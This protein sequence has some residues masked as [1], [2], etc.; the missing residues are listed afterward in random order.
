MT[1]LAT[2]RRLSER[3]CFTAVTSASL[4]FSYILKTKLVL[5]L[6][7]PISY[8]CCSVAMKGDDTGVGRRVWGERLRNFPPLASS[9]RETNFS[10]FRTEILLNFRCPGQ[11]A[12]FIQ[13]AALVFRYC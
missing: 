3:R 4:C 10:R 7:L 9:V 13:A 12:S 2:P 1:P 8:L 6:L 11:K 5:S